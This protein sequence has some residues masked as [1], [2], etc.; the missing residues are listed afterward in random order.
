MNKQFNNKMHQLIAGLHTKPFA[1]LLLNLVLGF[2]IPFVRTGRVRI[3]AL[4]PE[5]VR[6][7]IPNQKSVQN[8]I[9]QVHAAAMMLLGETASGLIT[10]M[11]IPEQSLPLIKSM[12][13]KFI[14]RSSGALTATAEIK[15]ESRSQFLTE[16]GEITL[17]V[18]VKDEKGETPILIEATWA[19]IPKAKK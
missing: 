7:A 17:E 19:W 8:H 3:L 13:T 9:G 15:P 4:T 18:H 10:A 16:K 11:N 1:N 2:K 14:K 5:E 6:V 12:N